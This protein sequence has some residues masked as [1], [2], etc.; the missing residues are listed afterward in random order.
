MKNQSQAPSPESR[1]PVEYDIIII[2][3][4]L[5]GA[6]LACALAES[7]ARIAVVEAVPFQAPEQPSYDDRGLAL[8]L[9]SRSIL[10]SIRVWPEVS[11]HACPIRGIHV[12]DRGHFGFVRLHAGDIGADVLGYVVTARE[13]GRALNIAIKVHENIDVICP[14]QTTAIN[15][16]A[17]GISLDLAAEGHNKTVQCKLLVAAD[18]TRSDTCMR[19]GIQ[20]SSKDYGQTAIIANINTEKPHNNMAYERFTDSGPLALLPLIDLRCKMV[21]TVAAEEAG[22]YLNMEDAEF[23]EHAWSRFGRR[24]GRFTRVGN[25]NSYPLVLREA[26]QQVRD[27]VVLVGNSAHT[28]HP[29]G[30]QGLNLSLRDVAALAACLVPVLERGGDPGDR[31]VLENYLSLRRSDQRNIIRFTDGLATLFYN[32]QPVKVVVRNSAM[33]M[34][35]LVPPLRRKL[36]SIIM[37]ASPGLPAVVQ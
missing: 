3:G 11:P 27:R 1:A 8:S 32:H 20:T 2:G 24:L 18:G 29:N 31:M 21:F 19:L 36:L 12:S 28:I 9:S 25:R 15:P 5:A 10:E 22:Y 14:A 23:L 34:M 16:G 26:E 35:D 30:A 37:G 33:L 13:L 6:G 7:G 4:G 17:E